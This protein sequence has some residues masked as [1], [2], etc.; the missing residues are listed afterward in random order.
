MKQ[1]TG[2]RLMLD[3]LDREVGLI[4]KESLAWMHEKPPARRAASELGHIEKLASPVVVDLRRTG[5]PAPRSAYQ[6]A[7]SMQYLLKPEPQQVET[8][9]EE[10]E[11]GIAE[12]ETAPSTVVDAPPIP[13][14]EDA[15]PF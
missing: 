12:E 11:I 8:I 6:E 9:E 1:F 15:M 13:V 4:N 10:E 7:Y 5:F 2:V 14:E 3:D